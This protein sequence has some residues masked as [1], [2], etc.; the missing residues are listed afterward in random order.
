[1]K[2]ARKCE[3]AFESGSTKRP[4]SVHNGAEGG[5]QWG[6]H[7]FRKKAGPLMVKDWV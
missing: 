2:A 5:G 1:V 6:V 7:S 4:K 3:K